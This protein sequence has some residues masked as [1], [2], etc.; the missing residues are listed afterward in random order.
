MHYGWSGV[1]GSDVCHFVVISIKSE[2]LSYVWCSWLMLSFSSY[3][4]DFSNHDIQ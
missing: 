3:E 1:E 2:L 4:E